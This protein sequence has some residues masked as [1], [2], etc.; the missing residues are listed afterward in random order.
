PGR[1]AQRRGS[2]RNPGGRG[3]ARTADGPAPAVRPGGRHASAGAVR[4]GRGR[5]AGGGS[6]GGTSG[7]GATRRTGGRGGRSSRGGGFSRGNPGCACFHA[8]GPAGSRGNG[9][10]RSEQRLRV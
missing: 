3:T 5:S 2:G 8:G 9:A 4:G 1:A 10:V 7:T 6:A